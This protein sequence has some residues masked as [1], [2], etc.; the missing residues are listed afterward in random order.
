[1][2]VFFIHKRLKTYVD[3]SVGLTQIKTEIKFDNDYTD[4][5]PGKKKW[6][7]IFLLLLISM[8]FFLVE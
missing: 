1:M 3:L 4:D 7:E 5:K 6:G 8:I 2:C